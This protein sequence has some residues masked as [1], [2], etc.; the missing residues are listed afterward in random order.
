[1]KAI[2]ARLLKEN[3]EKDAQI[4][5]QSKQ[6]VDLAKQLEKQ[7]PEASNKGL[8]GEDSCKESNH[9]EQSDNECK[10]KKESSLSSMSAERIE[11]LIAEAVK[12]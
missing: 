7:T 6:I 2:L 4:K 11:S 12:A 8:D 9:N 1:M 10:L 5:L 3:A